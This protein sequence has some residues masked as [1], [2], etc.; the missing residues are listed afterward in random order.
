M[1]EMEIF[2]RLNARLLNF[3]RLQVLIRTALLHY[4]GS[5]V[6]AFSAD[7][8]QM[9]LIAPRRPWP[10]ETFN[11]AAHKEGNRQGTGTE[12]ANLLACERTR[13]ASDKLTFPPAA[14][15]D[16]RGVS[17]AALGRMLAEDGRHGEVQSFLAVGCSE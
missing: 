4:R 5:A 15:P 10:V 8:T 13:V 1:A 9:H 14:G 6:L 11:L 16:L 3:S 12:Q 2:K 7:G 17:A